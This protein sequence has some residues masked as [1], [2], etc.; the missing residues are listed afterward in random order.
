MPTRIEQLGGIASD[1]ITVPQS[2][3]DL[4]E[5]V[6][7]SGTLG[8]GTYDRAAVLALVGGGVTALM[9][10]SITVASGTAD[11]AQTGSV[12][13]LAAGSVIDR[14]YAPGFSIND[15]TLTVDAGSSA[16]LQAR[17]IA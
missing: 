6:S 16:Y 17:G 11:F 7:Y 12:D 3:A 10:M 9:S 8:P 1:A 15:F 2:A 14:P 5:S 13:D 4:I